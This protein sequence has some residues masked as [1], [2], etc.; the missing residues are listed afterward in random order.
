MLQSSKIVLVTN[1]SMY[2][3][4]RKMPKKNNERPTFFDRQFY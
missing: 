2:L 4:N 1:W 3:E